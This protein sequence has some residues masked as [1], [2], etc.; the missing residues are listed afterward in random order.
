GDSKT[1]TVTNVA[2]TVAITGAPAT[3]PEGATISLGSNVSDPSSA[4]TTAG[5]S[6][7]WSVTRD[8]SPFASGSAASFSFTPDDGGSYVVTLTATDKDGGQGSDSRTIAVPD[9]NHAPSFTKGPDQTVL[10]DAGP[11]NVAHW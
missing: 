11:Q 5:F 10:E 1:V 3:G 2:P 7:A 9:V 6:I 8:G 4:D